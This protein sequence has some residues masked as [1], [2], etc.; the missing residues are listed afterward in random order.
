[1][2]RR[3]AILTAMIVSGMPASA[4]PLPKVVFGT[5][6]LAEAEHGGFYEAQALGLYKK[7]GIDVTIKM[8]GPQLNGSA[9]I[10]T[11]QVDFQ[12]SSGSLGVLNMVQ[13]HVPVVAVAAFFQKDPQVLI[14]HPGE[15][16]DTMEEL[17]GHPIMISTGARDGY[18]RFLRARFGYTDDMIRPYNFSVA[19][20]LVNKG[21]SM[22][23]FLSSEPYQIEQQGGFKPVIHLL[24]DNGFENYSGVILTQSKTVAEKPDL[25]RAFV[26]ASAEGWYH[27]MYGDP[28]PGNALILAS[29]PDMKQAIIDNSIKVM[30]E[31]GIVDSGDSLTMGIGAMS[32]ERWARFLAEMTKSG[33]YPPGMDSTA[34]YTTQFV[35][36]KIGMDIKPK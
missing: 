11:G 10:A 30:R 7:H 12:L 5:D 23:G 6:W 32:P 26:D 4:Q 8:G 14:S 19:P 13:Q 28:G 1:M 35:N 29:N 16:L 3:L 2:I 18:W 25:V 31:Y 20:F 21:L 9:A 27:Y 17:K 36:R 22:Q 33:I 34:A 24:A 15:G